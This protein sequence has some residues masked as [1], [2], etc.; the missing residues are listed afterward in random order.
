MY[1][2]VCVLQPVG[3]RHVNAV[4]IQLH[5]PVQRSPIASSAFQNSGCCCHFVGSFHCLPPRHI[6]SPSHTFLVRPFIF[7]QSFRSPLPSPFPHSYSGRRQTWLH[8]A[9]HAG[10]R[11]SRELRDFRH[12]LTCCEKCPTEKTCYGDG[13]QVSFHFPRGLKAPLGNNA[14]KTALF[15]LFG[16]KLVKKKS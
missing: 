14:D 3:R 9:N 5:C 2:C 8:C 16:N 12:D 6:H 10:L 13:P 15:S 4:L 1:V 7:L 11:D